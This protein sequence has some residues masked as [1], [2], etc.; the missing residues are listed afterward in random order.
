ML[1]NASVSLAWTSVYAGLAAFFLVVAPRFRG[2]GYEMLGLAMAGVS[3][4]S[5]GTWIALISGPSV[6]ALLGGRMLILGASLAPAL[7]THFLARFTRLA[8][9]ERWAPL[10]YVVGAAICLAD[11]VVAFELSTTLEDLSFPRQFLSPSPALATALTSVF[12]VHLLVGVAALGLALKRGMT[13]AL[14]PFSLML[15]LGPVVAFDY[16]TIFRTGSNYYVTESL[17]WVY[18][19]VI[20][21]A[22]LSELRGTE[23]LL[24]RTTSSLAERTAELQVSYAEIE[25]M[26]T[27]LSRKEQLAAVGELAAAIAHEVRNPLAI[28]MNA[29]SGR[30]RKTLSDQDKFTLLCIVDEE[31]ARLNQLVTE[32]LRFARPVEAARAPASLVDICRQ[33]QQAAPEGYVVEIEQP[34]EA[35]VDT[36]LVDSGL[37][38][39]ALDNLLLNAMQAMPGG[40]KV[41]VSIGRSKL[42]DGTPA[43]SVDV[44]DAGHGMGPLD[45]ERARKPFFTTR[46]RG[47]GLGLPIVD[48][49]LEAHGGEVGIES[50][51]GRGT[52]VTLKLPLDEDP[53]PLPGRYPGQ[54][55][56]SQR[57]RLRSIPHIG[58]V[59]STAQREQNSVSEPPEAPL[60]P[61]PPFG[62]SSS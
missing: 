45:L 41:K 6:A 61:S 52:T 60:P 3:F 20:V 40:G 48:R 14:L 24:E 23:G 59:T 62:G 7:N 8:R 2:R 27:E 13:S 49:I 51:L 31:S 16:N 38:R 36:A 35:G 44:R 37:F 25:L 46:P 29:A 32:L 57:R 55:T 54:K 4:A 42:A 33:V 30:R 28:I 47:T 19:L 17:T 22:L 43:A 5:L 15:V 50:E 34:R 10:G 11:L 21:A 12:A 58:T 56:P 39:L 1:G 9:L 53:P 18:G 26:H